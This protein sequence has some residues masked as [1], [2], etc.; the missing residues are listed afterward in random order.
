M[1]L[2]LMISVSISSKL[3]QGIFVNI[4]HDLR[5]CFAINIT[6]AQLVLRGGPGWRRSV[7]WVRIANARR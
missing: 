6:L 2:K 4:W 1:Q 5:W 3:I 7:V